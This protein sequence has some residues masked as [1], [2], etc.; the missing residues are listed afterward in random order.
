LI[1]WSGL[2]FLPETE[3]VEVA[4]LL[5]Q[6]FWGKGLAT[7]AARACVQ[8]GFENVGLESIVGIVH[9]E[10]IASQRVMEKLGM[11]FVDQSTY[12]GMECYRYSIDRS[13]FDSK[14]WNHFQLLD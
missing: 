3:E 10:N 1:G 12:F 9:P 6:A 8:Y 13:S 4:Y 5:G 11:S 7:E 2:T 14:A